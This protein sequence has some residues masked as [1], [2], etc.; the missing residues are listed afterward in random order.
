MSRAIDRE[1]R[2]TIP[3]RPTSDQILEQLTQ[4]ETWRYIESKYVPP[5][6]DGTTQK[7]ARPNWLSLAQE[8]EFTISDELERDAYQALFDFLRQA[9]SAES[10]KTKTKRGAQSNLLEDRKLTQERLGVPCRFHASLLALNA[11]EAGV[12]ALPANCFA[13]FGQTILDMIRTPVP[14]RSIV[15]CMWV[16][17][18]LLALAK[19]RDDSDRNELAHR[20]WAE[21]QSTFDELYDGEGVI[22]G[23]ISSWSPVLF[24]SFVRAWKRTRNGKLPEPSPE[25][26]SSAGTWAIEIARSYD[27]ERP[28][29]ADWPILNTGAWLRE[30]ISLSGHAKL[31]SSEVKATILRFAEGGRQPKSQSVLASGHSEWSKMA[32]LRSATVPGANSLG[33]NYSQPNPS[34]CLAHQGRAWLSGCIETTLEINGESIPVT[35]SWEDT[36]WH[37]DADV[38]YLEI[39]TRPAENVRIQRHILLARS[40]EF[41]LFADAILCDPN[42]SI[43]SE[44]V[45]PIAENVSM[46]QSPETREGALIRGKARATIVAPSTSE[47]RSEKSS[48]E[49]Q[50]EPDSVR[51]TCLGTHRLFAPLW[52]DL[53][54][55]RSRNMTTWRR[56]TV[57]QNLEI[58][59]RSEAEAFLVRTSSDQWL[60]YRS[61]GSKQ[62]RTI[63]GKNLATEFLVARFLETGLFHTIMEVE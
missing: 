49:L 40:D 34:I 30:F 57:G 3:E 31:S 63:L 61:L 26:V 62:N 29:F 48:A 53:N 41:A 10:R 35:S 5:K 39:E 23:E 37:E 19:W 21:L 56:L 9:D 27:G 11:A 13:T 47:W 24:I 45:F 51:L 25:L 4:E 12:C 15:E 44:V 55:K 36:L 22:H 52:V 20:A 16:T 46:E 58:P 38:T 28:L 7:S 17:E 18:G 60:I 42:V 33:L 43:R 32:L 6:F 50:F 14:S 8:T 54:P 1:P 59:P 2:I